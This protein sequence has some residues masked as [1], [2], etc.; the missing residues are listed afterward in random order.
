MSVEVQTVFVPKKDKKGEQKSR[1]FDA[2]LL[3]YIEANGMWDT[4]S[5]SGSRVIRPVFARIAAGSSILSNVMANLRDGRPLEETRGYNRRRWEFL[6]SVKYSTETKHGE[7]GS[8]TTIYA[9]RLFSMDSHERAMKFILLTPPDYY[10]QHGDDAETVRFFAYVRS[11]T[12][13]PLIPTI[14]FARYLLVR[15]KE[16]GIAFLRSKALGCEAYGFDDD[17]V[18]PLFVYASDFDTFLAQVTQEYRERTS[19]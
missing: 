13:L 3:C 9:P 8:V 5:T 12:M 19:S 10:E 2:S 1:T 14:E 11:R 15:A 18:P 17:P 16:I 7:S 6:R 4:A